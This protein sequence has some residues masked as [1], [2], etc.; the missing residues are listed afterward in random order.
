[1]KIDTIILQLAILFLPGL[2]W[3][4]LDAR[5]ALKTKPSDIEFLLRTF[6]FGLSSY[7]VT[8]LV[9]SALGRQ[10][11]VVDLTEVGTQPVVTNAVFK[12]VLW[13]TGIGLVLGII[14]IYAATYK[15]LTRFLQFIRATRTYGDEDVWDYTF[16]SS[17]PAVEYA[18]FRDFENKLVYAGWVKEYSETEKLRELV[19]R[20]VQIF[21][22]EGTLQYEI[23]LLYLARAPENV[24]IEFPYQG[25]TPIPAGQPDD[26]EAIDD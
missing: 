12:E 26:T 19:L 23:P 16:N 15:W 7:A 25:G 9:F 6:L 17:I 10:F 2:I 8:F 22:F 14:W 21:D 4:R 3:A 1:V 20:D 24:H 18:H 11:T 13:A 5:F